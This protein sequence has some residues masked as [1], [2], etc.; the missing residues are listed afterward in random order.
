MAGCPAASPGHMLAV[1]H[2]LRPLI[3]SLGGL[4]VATGIYAGPDDLVD[5]AP[6]PGARG[7]TG[8]RSERGGSRRNRR[9]RTIRSRSHTPSPMLARARYHRGVNR[10][11]QGC[12]EGSRPEVVGLLHRA[13]CYR[14][15]VIAPRFAAGRSAAAREVLAPA[16]AG[17]ER[18]H[19]EGDDS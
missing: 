14:D 12:H 7:A 4:T 5:G 10:V 15:D 6:G 3:A 13:V 17:R 1:D 2:G 9:S 16:R 18:Y 8:C 11:L 19:T